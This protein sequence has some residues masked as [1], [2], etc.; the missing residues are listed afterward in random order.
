MKLLYLPNETKLDDI[1]M[2]I[3]PRK[4]FQALLDQGELSGLEIFSF[5]YEAKQNQ[6]NYAET[7]QKL[8]EVAQSFQPEAIFWQHVGNFEVTDNFIKSLCS[9]D[10]KPKL[11]YQ[12]GDAYGRYLKRI[13][14]NMAMLIRNSEAIFLV[15]LGSLSDLAF[16]FG[17]KRVYYAPNSFDSSRFGT[18]WNPTD[19]REN[20]LTLIGS[21]VGATRI[22]FRYFPGSQ[23]RRNLAI[24]L[25]NKFKE[26]FALYGSGWSNVKSSRGLIPFNLQEQAIRAS[27]LSI[28][29]THFDTIPYYF[30]N[31]LPISL[32]AGV[33]HIT[34]YQP[35][36]EQVFR[37][38]RGGLYM[39]KTVDE[40]VELA[41]YLL[42]QPRE[43]LIE[44]GLKGQ[45]FAFSHLEANVVYANILKKMKEIFFRKHMKIGLAT[46]I[47]L[48]PLRPYLPALTDEE[49]KLGL[50]GTSVTNLALGMLEGG[51]SLSI[52][53]LSPK[54]EAPRVWEG[55]QLKVFM[56]QYRPVGR[57]RMWDF[58]AREIQQIQDFIREDCPD[59]VNAHW[60]YE[61]ALGAIR[62]GYPHLITFRDSA[63][64]ILKLQKDLYRL[65]RYLLDAQVK[66]RASTSASILLIFKKSWPR[67][68][69]RSPLSPTLF[70]R[71]P[72]LPFPKSIPAR[73]SKLSVW[74]L[75]LT[76]AK[77]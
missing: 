63:W 36:Y 69:P 17:A 28:N 35:G 12:D 37:N 16:E 60:S 42:S 76:S 25:S 74:P 52:Y 23:R 51:Q 5:L 53:S 9:I 27:W 19:I 11:F 58:F 3:G 7:C 14:K 67:V 49:T 22:P 73:I 44:E 41:Q 48:E 40:A 33:V 72:F 62:S 46:P 70:R 68:F 4:A 59:I 47:D 50:G 57:H 21:Y 29:W 61:F 31:R 65:V 45:E 8:L 32:A 20:D 15:G 30:S 39:A 10:S 56:G 77:T 43:F 66:K 55:P 54:L 34:N 26:R 1:S 64:E 38:C 75:L 2:Q 24:K 71:P 6:N 18:N 13:N